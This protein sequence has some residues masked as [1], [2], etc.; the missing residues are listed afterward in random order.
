M[1]RGVAHLLTRMYPRRWRERYGEEFEDLLR[2]GRG[3]VGTWMDV[4]RAA[5]SEH[6]HPALQAIGQGMVEPGAVESGGMMSEVRTSFGT[7][8]RQPSALVPLVMALTA[9]AVVLCSL[10]YDMV[11]HGAIVREADEGAIAHIWQLLMVAQLPALLVFGI[12]WLP[13]A[14]KQAIGVLALLAA[15]ILAA[16]A[17]VFIFHL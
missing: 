3:D 7:V 11:T 4:V 2:E 16:M 13:K 9:L 15:A 14:P 5:V 1:K 6:F 12:R 17:P 8:A 10:G